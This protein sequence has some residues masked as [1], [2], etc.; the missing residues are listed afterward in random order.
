MVRGARGGES[1]EESEQLEFV[2]GIEQVGLDEVNGR[3]RERMQAAA[4]K[5]KDA[6][7]C[8]AAVVNAEL[9]E[10]FGG[11]AGIQR[12]R[13]AV[14]GVPAV[15]VGNCAPAK[16]SRPLQECD[17]HPRAGQVASRRQPGN[18]ASDNNNVPVGNGLRWFM[19]PPRST[20]RDSPPPC[21]NTSLSQSW[22]TQPTA[23]P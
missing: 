15:P 1:D 8:P 19:S 17:R 20:R 2:R 11:R 21:D 22:R 10:H 3:S 14:K 23:P 18:A 5:S 12:V 9:A 7:R 16:R 4:I 13:A 6:V